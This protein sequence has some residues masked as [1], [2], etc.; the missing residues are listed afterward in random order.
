MSPTAPTVAA[1]ET[2]TMEQAEGRWVVQELLDVRLLLSAEGYDGIRLV[3]EAVEEHGLD[4]VRAAA[5]R[6][7]RAPVA[8][9]QAAAVLTLGALG[10]DDEASRDLL[11]AVA[12][13][14]VASAD[15]GVREA[16]ADGLGWCST[17]GRTTLALLVLAD[18]E[19]PAVRLSAVQGLCVSADGEPEDGGEVAALLLRRFDDPEPLVRDWAVFALGVNRD[20]DTPA[21]RTALLARLNDDAA[22]T[23]GEAAVAL[24]RRRDARV[25]PVLVEHLAG[26]DVGNLWVEAAAELAEPALLP[27]LLALRDA[28]WGDEDARPEVLDHAIASCSSPTGAGP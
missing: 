8:L 13:G 21:L 28:G 5:G 14:L 23:A 9:E 1:A 16:L 2:G 3:L 24:A 18:D 12:T 10:I 26:T 17:D 27:A 4:Q 22:D 7:A 19:E 15:A 6:A 20:L 25:L 11:V